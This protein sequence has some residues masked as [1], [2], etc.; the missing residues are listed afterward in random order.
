MSEKILESL[1]TDQINAVSCVDGPS[2]IIAGPGS[3]KTK[4]LTHKITYIIQNKQ[5]LPSNILAVTFTNKAALEMKERVYK[6]ILKFGIGHDENIIPRWIGTFHSISSRILRKEAMHVGMSNNFVIYDTDDSSKI[7]K[8]ILDDLNISVKELKPRKVLSSIS[9]LKGDLITPEKYVPDNNTFYYQQIARI[10]PIYEQRL[11]LSNA[12]DFNDLLIKIVELFE[13]NEKVLKKYQEQF[14]YI[15]IDEYQDTNTVQYKIVRLLSEK[16]KNLTVVGDV[17]QSIYSWRGADYRNMLLFKEDFEEAKIFQLAQNYR[18]TKN[19]VEAAKSLIQNNSTHMKLDLFTENEQGAL[20]TLFEAENERQESQFIVDMILG[21][22]EKHDFDRKVYNEIA[23]L[24]RTNAQSRSIEEVLIQRGIPYK[25]VG[26]IRF[27]DRREIKD[28][29]AYLKVFYNPSDT[30]AW[31]RCINTPAR[32]IGTKTL[33][34][35]RESD[36]ELNMIEDYTKLE[37]KKYIQ[38]EQDGKATPLELL[39]NVLKNFGYLQYLNDGTEE[40]LTR[41]ENI[42]ELRTVA[43]QFKTLA[44]FLENIMLVESSSKADIGSDGQITLM[45]LHSA[46]GLEFNQVFLMGMEEGVFPHS[47]SIMDFEQLEEE[48]RLCYVGITRAKKELYLTYT[49]QRTIFGQTNYS[50]IS[51]FIS[52]IPERLIGYQFG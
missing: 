1:N 10:Y 8:E 32:G 52:E 36:Y 26:G 24:Y 33:A 46:K 39:D 11:R 3:G 38:K 47:R 23:V 16:H 30:V 34:K 43:K 28:V 17:S 50:L 9:K 13:N 45:T 40:G 29:I 51:R 27:Y 37:W 20:L 7:I 44:D 22:L 12:V 5:V 25:I 18:S 41:I 6:L 4:A 49:R 14:K 31:G 21:Y 15:L 42:K 19:I 48:R 2:L 35:I